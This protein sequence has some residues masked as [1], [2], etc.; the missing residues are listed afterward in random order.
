MANSD[1]PEG[2]GLNGISRSRPIEIGVDVDV[3]CFCDYTRPFVDG[4]KEGSS[5]SDVAGQAFKGAPRSGSRTS[6]G[7]R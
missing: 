2:E 5:F 4:D 6:G 3:E 1:S 7:E